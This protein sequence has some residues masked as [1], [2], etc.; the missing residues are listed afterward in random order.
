MEDNRLVSDGWWRRESK[1]DD[2][3][4]WRDGERLRCGP[5]KSPSCSTVI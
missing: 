3:R 2:G 1:E 4:G 5:C